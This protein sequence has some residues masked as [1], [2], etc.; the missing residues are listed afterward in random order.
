MT[1]AATTCPT[2]GTFSEDGFTLVE[3]LVA[4]LLLMIGFLAVITVFWTSAASGTFTLRCNAGLG[5]KCSSGRNQVNIRTR[6]F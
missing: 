2:K 5:R 6:W 1:A 4:I 3:L